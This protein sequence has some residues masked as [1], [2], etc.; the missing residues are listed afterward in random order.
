M[1]KDQI[2]TGIIGFGLSG[3]VFHA[4]FLH[5]HKG[6]KLEKIVERKSKESKKIY[7]YVE[8]V[9]DYKNLVNDKELDLIV[10]CTPNTLHA[11]MAKECLEAGKHV[12]IEKPFTPTAKEADELIK[13]A[14]KAERNI[15]VYHNRRW[16]G[17]FMTLKKI[18]DEKILGDIY[19][20]EAH[21]DRYTPDW[22][23]DSWRDKDIAGG[24]ILFDLGAHLIDQA[25][26]L[27]GYPKKV[28]A[29]IQAQ[30][31]NSPVDDYFHLELEYPKLKVILTAGM[32]VKELGPRFTLKGNKGTYKKSGIDPQ[33]DLLKA[34][35]MPGTTNWGKEKKENWG[36]MDVAID[37]KHSVYQTET[38]AGNYMGFYDNVYDVIINNAEMVVKQKEAR[39]V[40]K[41]I[42]M[43]FTDS[44]K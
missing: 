37:G 2:K 13:L 12:I 20:Y 19:E 34:G 41:I 39:N 8:V 24:G 23:S 14:E 38:L 22:D 36:I 4:P 1:I 16:D 3:K 6:F 9:S 31:K 32:M 7:P 5:T 33:E 26:Y 21:F 30:R 44:K 27:F 10:I 35:L 15:F 18:I 25:M 43:A 42:E 29:N 28:T 40:I 11:P 17:D